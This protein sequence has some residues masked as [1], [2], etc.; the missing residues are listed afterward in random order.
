VE[1]ALNLITIADFSLRKRGSAMA[2]SIGKADKKTAG[3]PVEHK[4]FPKPGHADRPNTDLI[5]RCN[6]IPLV[7]DHKKAPGVW[8][9]TMLR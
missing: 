3:C 8:L 1:R 7:W 5:G 4:L 9:L 6:N 2:A